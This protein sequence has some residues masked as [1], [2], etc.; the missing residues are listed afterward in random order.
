MKYSD[1][2]RATPTS[3]PTVLAAANWR[4]R[5]NDSGTIGSGVR[6]S[7]HSQVQIS[8]TAA[9]SRPTISGDVQ[10]WSLVLIRPYVSASRPLVMSTVPTTSSDCDVTSRDSATAHRQTPTAMIPIGTLTQNTD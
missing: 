8:T 7:H 1:P 3:M 5:K 6:A 2:N 9:P 10:E 4:I